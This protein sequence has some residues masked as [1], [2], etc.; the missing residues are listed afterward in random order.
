MST[1]DEAD[2]RARHEPQNSNETFRHLI[3]TACGMRLRFRRFVVC[4]FCCAFYYRGAAQKYMSDI[5]IE[6]S[7]AQQLYSSQD[8]CQFNEVI[9]CACVHLFQSIVVSAFV[10]RPLGLQQ[11]MDS[12]HSDARTYVRTH[13]FM[14]G[15]SVI[16]RASQTVRTCC[17]YSAKSRPPR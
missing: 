7:T 6:L 1:N 8:L 14:N 5:Y 4:L 10:A 16:N 13:C 12:Q 15:S 2:A 3:A 11:T 17:W 9:S